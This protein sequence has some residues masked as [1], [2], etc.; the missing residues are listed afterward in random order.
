MPYAND[1]QRRWVV[2][3]TDGAVAPSEDDSPQE[4]LQ[5]EL[6]RKNAAIEQRDRK[7][8]IAYLEQAYREVDRAKAEFRKAFIF[9]VE[10]EGKRVSSLGEQGDQTKTLG[11]EEIKQS[12]RDEDSNQLELI[13]GATQLLD[14]IRDGLLRHSTERWKIDK[15]QLVEEKISLFTKKEVM[16]SIY[17][18][19]VRELVIPEGFIEKEF[20]QVQQMID[21]S[22]KFY[23]EELKKFKEPE[24]DR[25][26]DLKKATTAI[27]TFTKA[28]ENV[29]LSEAAA[30]IA[31]SFTDLATAVITTSIDGY[32]AVT[33]Q[34]SIAGAK[35]VMSDISGIVGDILGSNEYSKALQLGIK[36]SANLMGM[37][38]CLMKDEPDIDG[39]FS[40]VITSVGNGF[41]AAGLNAKG[42]KAAKIKNASSITTSVLSSLLAAKKGQVLKQI[43]TGAWKDV[44]TF[45][46]S[47]TAKSL[48]TA[49]SAMNTTEGVKPAAELKEITEKLKT[50][51]D[52][53][54]KEKLE[55]EKE[56]LEKEL[57]EIAERTE[58]SGEALDEA[59]KGFGE[60]LAIDKERVEALEKAEK[61]K[62]NE[63]ALAEQQ[64]IEAQLKKEKEAF[65]S[66]LSS[67][68]S[69][70]P[71]E[72]ELKSIAHLIDQLNRDR[73]IMTLAASIG[74]ATAG[75]LAEFFKP[76]QAAGTLVQ[77]TV[78]L[79]A[80]VERAQAMRLWIESRG[81]AISAVSPY[82]TTIENFVKNQKDQFA[83]Y[84]IKAALNLVKAGAQIAGS[85]GVT[86]HITK[87][88]E[89]GVGLAETAEE[90]LYNYFR[91]EQLKK[92]WS[93]T[94][95]ALMNPDDRRMALIARQ[96]NPT[97]AKYTIAYGAVIQ[98]EMIAMSAMNKIGLD[99]ETLAR[100]DS[101]VRE[102]KG[103]LDTLYPDD[104]VV[105]GEYVNPSW[106]EGLP[107]PAALNVKCWLQTVTI[108][109]KNGKLAKSNH[110]PIVSALKKIETLEQKFQQTVAKG[111]P[112]PELLDDYNLTL[113]L[114]TSAI[115]LYEPL[116]D[117][118]K[119]SKD[120]QDVARGFSDVAEVKL[121]EL[122]EALALA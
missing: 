72:N 120:M 96:L 6:L 95:Q 18:P 116:D 22:N 14:S 26:E 41:S 54:E 36:S 4:K 113:K 27:S 16:D 103:Y 93:I 88:V 45:M 74:S 61:L 75:V 85:A 106:K 69:V 58:L 31:N 60:T 83:H 105:L 90:I 80:A 114:L 84:T 81:E 65:V 29:K 121:A 82:A 47:T 94:K 67:L 77:F 24:T 13:A 11:V 119:V 51:E 66:G 64:D 53:E 43:Q 30:K 62:E 25:S 48:K 102:V 2:Q 52:K 20:S 56:R 46:A 3:F 108:A 89:A 28:I 37:A 79:H 100:K 117:G 101:G 59:A 57:E 17:T 76:M 107:P 50:V 35:T 98:K 33:K 71:D 111:K 78:N 68:G 86:A 112:D 87:A 39:F 10:R 40:E 70:S 97:L 19:L 122:T 92:A 12:L 8:K 23:L 49:F 34:Q 115:E 110:R 44:A 118:D 99:R 32:Q 21:E 42:E 63:V 9:E 73:Q 15:D 55:Q 1:Q 38:G 109:K 7:L 5:F 104:L 91:E